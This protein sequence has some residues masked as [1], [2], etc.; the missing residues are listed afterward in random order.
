[1]RSKARTLTLSSWCR[2]DPGRGAEFRRSS[3]VLKEVQ[4][5]RPA[6][7]DRRN[8][9]EVTL[10]STGWNQTKLGNN[11]ARTRPRFFQEEQHAIRSIPLMRGVTENEPHLRRPERVAV[12]RLE[13]AD[14]D[15]RASLVRVPDRRPHQRRT[16]RRTGPRRIAC[17]SRRCRSRAATSQPRSTD[18]LD[19]VRPSFTGSTAFAIS[20]SFCAAA[21]GSAKARSTIYSKSAW[22]STNWRST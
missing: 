15:S 8:A 12:L 14:L 20:I 19:K 2:P 18:Q 4:G 22:F 7:R 10:L 6:Y 1:V 11:L 3:A 9:P 13:W 5:L 16:H 21:F 17:A